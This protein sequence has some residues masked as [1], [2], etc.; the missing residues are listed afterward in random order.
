MRIPYG[1][2]IAY[3]TKRNILFYLLGLLMIFISVP[4]IIKTV[5]L[6]LHHKGYTGA[7][8]L[9]IVF[10]FLFCGIALIHKK[11]LYTNSCKKSLLLRYTFFGLPIISDTLFDDIQYVGA[12]VENDYESKDFTIKIWFANNKFQDIAYRFNAESALDLGIILSEALKVKLLDNT[13][14]GQKNWIEN[15]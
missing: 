15:E 9:T 10:F 12:H 13:I 7:K 6:F 1:Y 3:K 11:E 8:F 4:V 14:K 2:E 5:D